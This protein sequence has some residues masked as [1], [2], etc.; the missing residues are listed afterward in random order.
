[1]RKPKR[2]KLARDL[3]ALT[4]GQLLGKTIGFIAFAY[5]ARVLDPEAYGAVEYAVG[6]AVFFAVIVDWGLGPIGVREISAAPH[7]ASALGALIPATRLGI[8]V[9][10]IP[11]MGLTT[12][13]SGHPDTTVQLVWLFSL[14]LLALP[15][16]Q[17][18]L[19]QA[20]ELMAADAA[21]Q[22]LRTT[23]FALGVVLFVHSP[24]DILRVGMVEIVA[25]ALG[26][27]YYLVVQQLW[28]VPVRLR[29]AAPDMRHLMQQGSFLG[30]TNLLWTM[31]QYVPLF[32][33][34]NVV[35]ASQT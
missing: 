5:L 10:V 3:F 8:A 2:F 25:A 21:G 22:L 34:A 19:L 15:W 11:L 6:L 9:V 20:R 24:H 16:K 31:I 1:M 27:A 30:L 4:S 18:W 13:W 35:G 26:A 29:F 14:S 33:V 7:R 32:L 28:I 23:G 17:D 12:A